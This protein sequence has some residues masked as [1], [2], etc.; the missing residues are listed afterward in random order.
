VPAKPSI[1]CFRGL[2][3]SPG[4]VGRGAEDG[5]SISGVKLAYAPA[6]LRC[7]ARPM[8][9]PDIKN[10]AGINRTN[11]TNR[12]STRESLPRNRNDCAHN[13]GRTAKV[14]PG[15]IAPAI[16]PIGTKLRHRLRF[17]RLRPTQKPKLAGNAKASPRMDTSR[18][19]SPSPSRYCHQGSLS[20][21]ASHPLRC[22]GRSVPSWAPSGADWGS[23]LSGSSSTV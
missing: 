23:A 9:A 7:N 17:L 1:A 21:G 16:N 10:S 8:I 19:I 18:L 5:S 6:V 2:Q 20:T 4:V 11:I 12:T 3:P 15:P 13:P 14:I 22:C